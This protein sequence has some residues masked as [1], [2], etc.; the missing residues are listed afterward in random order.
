MAS[1]YLS[2]RTSFFVLHEQQMRP[3]SQYVH[4]LQ[5]I[6]MMSQTQR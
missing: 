3:H 5:M 2:T 6:S 1:L 4:S